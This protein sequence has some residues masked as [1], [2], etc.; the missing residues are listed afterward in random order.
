[1]STRLSDLNNYRDWQ[2]FT[3]SP[4][5][6]A[7]DDQFTDWYARNHT[8]NPGMGGAVPHVFAG[9]QNADSAGKY[10]YNAIRSH[11]KGEPVE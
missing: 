1:M 6:R 5:R 9:L 7:I 8:P 3:E 4:R 10:F 11:F 2:N